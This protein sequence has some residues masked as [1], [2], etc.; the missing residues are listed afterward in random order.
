VRIAISRVA[1]VAG[2]G[3][4]AAFAGPVGALDLAGGSPDVTVRIAGSSGMSKAFAASTTAQLCQPGTIHV[5]WDDRTPLG[6]LG[7]E[8]GG[9]YQAYFCSAKA[10]ITGIAAG[11]RLLIVKRDRDGSLLGVGPVINKEAVEFMKIDASCVDRGAAN[12]YPTPRFLCT[13]VE[14]AVPDGGLSDVERALW[15]ARGQGAQ[16]LPGG[17]VE[18][19][20]FFGQGFG[21]GVSDTLYSA[22]QAAQGLTVGATDAAN[23][24]RLARGQ[25]ASIV[26]TTGAYVNASFLTGVAGKLHNCRRPG[27]SGTQAASDIFFLD[28]PCQRNSP[29]L[30]GQF[31][32]RAANNYGPNLTV[33]ES[34]TT[35]DAIACLKDADP[36]VAG[37]ELAIGPIALENI[38]SSG[39]KFVKL[40]GVSPNFYTTDPDGA[41][42]LKRGDPDPTQ[43]KNVLLGQYLFAFEGSM[44]WRGDS[45]FAGATGPLQLIANG[46]SSPTLAAFN[47]VYQVRKTGSTHALFPDRV[48]KAS[49]SGNSCQ[50]FLLLE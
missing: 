31:T 18:V 41:G 8:D 4:A 13:G 27:S 29:P 28:N 19:R 33:I 44:L 25:Y 37:Q 15:G 48:S 43:R 22:L 40:D 14:N 9:R 3:L 1:A 32:P 47:G 34:S 7:A 21:L 11:A 38:P 26:S 12:V 20:N 17:L 5:Y 2:L 24:P 16:T 49:R 39:W 35:A 10:G 42:P 36:G 30:F 6:V 23:Q 46:L 45:V 50:N